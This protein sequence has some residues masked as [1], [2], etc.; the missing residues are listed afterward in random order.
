MSPFQSVEVLDTLKVGIFNVRLISLSDGKGVIA[1][2]HKAAG[3]SEAVNQMTTK[4]AG[5]FGSTHV[6]LGVDAAWTN[7]AL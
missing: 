6:S 7:C 5:P 1:A 2:D 3:T 4:K